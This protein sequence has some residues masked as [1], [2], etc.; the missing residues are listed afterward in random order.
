[1]VLGCL[2]IMEGRREARGEKSSIVEG[3]NWKGKGKKEREAEYLYKLYYKGKQ[4]N[5]AWQCG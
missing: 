2:L 3:A 4:S 5:L 1:M